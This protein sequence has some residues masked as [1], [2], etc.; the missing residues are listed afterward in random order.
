MAMIE[1]EQTQERLQQ[2]ILAEQYLA[3]NVIF[4]L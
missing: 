4:L 1:R 3:G 2:Q